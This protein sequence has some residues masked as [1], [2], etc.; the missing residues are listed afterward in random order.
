M[1]Q[2]K[3]KRSRTTPFLRVVVSFI[4]MRKAGEEFFSFLPS[5]AA[6]KSLQS[7]PTL[8]DPTDG[9]PP[10]FPV[11]GILQARTLEWVAISFFPPKRTNSKGE[12]RVPLEVC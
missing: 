8:C 7:C 6:A 10:G 9:S 12:S 2:R 4:E 11:P 3:R 5:V 1:V